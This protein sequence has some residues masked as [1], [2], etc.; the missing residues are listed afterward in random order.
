MTTVTPPRQ[1]HGTNRLSEVARHLVAPTGIVKTYWNA[2]RDQCVDLGLAFDRWQD[3]AGRL[4]L[5]QR[6]NGR[7]AAGIGG[8]PLSWPLQGGKNYL[9][10]GIVIALRLRRPGVLGLGNGLEGKTVN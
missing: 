8:V 4:I 5:S 3:G 7:F 9:V 10:G 2:V 6:Q 1:R